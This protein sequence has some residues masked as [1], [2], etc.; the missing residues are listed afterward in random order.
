MT[1]RKMPVELHGISETN[2][3]YILQIKDFEKYKAGENAIIV[4]KS[5]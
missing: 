1:F 3:M 5:K 4:V 2:E